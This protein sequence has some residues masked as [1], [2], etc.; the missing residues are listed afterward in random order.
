M[1]SEWLI[2]EIVGVRPK[3]NGYE[4]GVTG[5]MGS[6]SYFKSLHPQG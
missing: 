1:V 6:L 2:V 3:K 4:I 5:E